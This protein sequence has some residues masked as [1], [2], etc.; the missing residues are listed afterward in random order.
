MKKILLVDDNRDNLEVLCALF[1]DEGFAVKKIYTAIGIEDEIKTFNPD[2]IFLDVMLGSEN[3]ADVCVKL[4]A[5]KTTS[6]IKIVLMTA[7]N[8]F[9]TLSIDQTCADYHLEKP[10]DI[11]DVAAI[12]HRLAGW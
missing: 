10:F 9:Q 11:D 1:E 3:G 4:K 5:G 7:S 12:A 2:V 6:N 8:K